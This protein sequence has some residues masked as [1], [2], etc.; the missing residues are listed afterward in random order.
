MEFVESVEV[1]KLLDSYPANARQRLYELRQLILETA[2]ELDGVHKLLE[3]TKWAEPSYVT[4]TG[5]TIRMD[6]KPKTPDNYYMFFICNTDLVANFRL[7]LGDE[8]VFEGKRAI[9]LDLDQAIPIESLKR[10]I[11]LALTYHKVKH[12][13]LLGE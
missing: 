2:E 3:T 13:P 8:L 5:S 7:I 11:R 6:W 12:L 10:C 4:K 9:V 1:I